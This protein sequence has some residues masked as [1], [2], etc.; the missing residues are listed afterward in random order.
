M[1]KTAGPADGG[2]MDQLALV[3]GA[4]GHSGRRLV[5]ELPKAGLRV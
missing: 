4:T 2:T 5:P 3:S 1:A